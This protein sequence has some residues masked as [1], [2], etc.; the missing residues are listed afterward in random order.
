MESWIAESRK[1]CRL[2]SESPP[3]P[4]PRENLAD[5]SRTVKPTCCA[6]TLLD[7]MRGIPLPFCLTLELCILLPIARVLLPLNGV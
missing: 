6:A 3:G 1:N 2:N 7:I 5:G 4:E